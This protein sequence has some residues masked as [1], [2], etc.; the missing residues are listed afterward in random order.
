MKRATGWRKQPED[1][2]DYDFEKSIGH[3]LVAASSDAEPSVAEFYPADVYD[4]NGYSM[5]ISETLLTHWRAARIR[6]GFPDLKPSEF[7]NYFLGRRQ[8]GLKAGLHL[9]DGGGYPRD[10]AKAMAH[11]GVC[12]DSIWSREKH[13]VNTPPSL[14]ALSNGYPAHGFEYYWIGVQNRTELIIE[15]LKQKH[16]VG[17]GT[18]V[19][20]EWFDYDPN[21]GD[22]L[23]TPKDLNNLAGHYISI[24]EYAG[25]NV[26]EIRH[27]WGWP[28]GYL[29]ARVI[30]N[31][32]LTHD[33]M[34]FVQH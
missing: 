9:A 17:L 4:Q 19:G 6:D 21:S 7:Y 10:F 26:F 30:E 33:I 18:M 15:A 16:F 13:R 22:V 24:K 8:S 3:R 14:N 12:L 27:W 28:D 20:D 1:N 11:Y 23:T 29:D 31:I 32:F 34:V 25:D 2:R 5:C